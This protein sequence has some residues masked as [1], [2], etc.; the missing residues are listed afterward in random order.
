MAW[1]LVRAIMLLISSCSIL[2]TPT[3]PKG[4]ALVKKNLPRISSRMPSKIS[5]GASRP[6]S[7]LLIGS[8]HTKLDNFRGDAFDEIERELRPQP[9]RFAPQ[10]ANHCRSESGS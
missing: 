2:K 4:L 7:A 5:P 10:S 8:N 6:E 9:I 1:L 3:A